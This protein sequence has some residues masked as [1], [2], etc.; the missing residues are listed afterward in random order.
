MSERSPKR[1]ADYESTPVP[2]SEYIA[3]MVHLYRGELY[4]ANSWR[5]RLDMTTNWS[6]LTTAG[7]FSFAFSDRGHSHWALLVGLALI[8]VFW[9]FESRR[10]RHAD[11]W[12][13]RVRSIEENFYGPL[14]RRDPI[15]PNQDWGEF[16]ARDLDRP[17]FKMSRLYALRA[18][19][20]R[21]YWAIYLVLLLAWCVKI[22][23]HPDM[24]QT[25]AEC[26]QRLGGGL[27]PWWSPLVYLGTFLLPV[28]GLVLFGPR[29]GSA[30]GDHE[31]V[32]L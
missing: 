17:R 14:L 10:F 5:L 31:Y 24:A 6:V 12:Y 30:G 29:R 9:G 1:L 26:R 2:R 27:L 11:V 4:R 18:R 32:S 8:T 15:S 3:A 28:L 21:N 7:L 25:W 23:V 19:L 16:V 20:L 22:L 13:S